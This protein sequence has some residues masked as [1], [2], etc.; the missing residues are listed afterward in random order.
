MR[1]A[2]ILFITIGWLMWLEI[3]FVGCSPQAQS[4]LETEVAKGAATA[5]NLAQTQ[6]AIAIQT[7]AVAAQ[8]EAV[9][10]IQTGA[11]IAQTQAAPVQT[12]IAQAA[13]TALA[14]QIQRA[15]T[16]AAS[17]QQTAVAELTR[18]APSRGGAAIHYFALGDSIASGHG[19]MDDGEPCHRSLKSYPR[20]VAELL[21]PHFQEIR[22]TILACSGATAAKPP[23]DKLNCDG[24]RFKWFRNQ[25]DE[26]LNQMPD[27]RPVLVTINIG[28]NDF[29]WTSLAN[30]LPHIRDRADEYL[31]WANGIADGVAQELRAQVSRL[32]ER[33]NAYVVITD[34]YNPFNHS[35][36]LFS[37]KGFQPCNKIIGQ[38]DCYERTKYGVDAMNNAFVL[39]VFVPLGRPSRLRA[40]NVNP[41]FYGHEAPRP[42]CGDSAPDV[43]ETWI[44]YPGQ[45]G[46]NGEVPDLMRVILT[47]EKY[48]DCFHPNEKGAQ[49]YANA[50]MEQFLRMK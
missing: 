41:K 1:I 44:Q 28:A 32:L 21:K 26:A 9:N 23:P 4:A 10:A 12:Q 27:D 50:V 3:M 35:S 17:I 48:G 7:G 25:V 5:M 38:L 29:G 14:A 8:T 19:L 30:L 20:Q 46:V 31:P 42:K 34:L 47:H 40:A 45:P 33:P 15:E 49:A 39:N 13:Q 37:L 36:M 2:L 43:D 18:L 24:C 6:A 16:Q 22:Y 11:V